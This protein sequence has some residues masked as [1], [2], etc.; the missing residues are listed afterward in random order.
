M[1]NITFWA[2]VHNP[3]GYRGVPYVI[4]EVTTEKGRQVYGRYRDGAST[5]VAERAVLA[6]LPDER[7][8][9]RFLNAAEKIKAKHHRPIK[10]AGQAL[11]TAKAAEE[12]DLTRL[13]TEY[14][15]E[16]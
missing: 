12:L 7:T 13:I 2:V 4:I 5:H 15:D 9:E 16:Q 14:R 11:I 10:E 8:A 1:K 6:R 3:C